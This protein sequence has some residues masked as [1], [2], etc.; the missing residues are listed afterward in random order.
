MSDT[1]KPDT[2]RRWLLTGAAG[3]VV[4]AMGV[5]LPL[6]ALAQDRGMPRNEP[7]L[8]LEERQQM[9][10]NRRIDRENRQQMRDERRS[11][12]KDYC[13]ALEQMSEA[14]RDAW[15]Q[16]M[17]AQRQR[18]MRMNPSERQRMREQM[19]NRTPGECVEWWRQQGE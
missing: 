19:M 10:E 16:E 18:M 7:G 17:R 2:R 1:N 5:S 11:M 12:R 14:E 6:S 15:R 3:L 9:R 13:P 4:L 8:T